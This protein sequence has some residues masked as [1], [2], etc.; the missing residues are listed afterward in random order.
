MY[1]KTLELFIF[2]LL[3]SGDTAN[4]IFI[5]NG[6]LLVIQNRYGERFRMV[7]YHSLDNK[8]FH[9]ILS[10][11]VLLQFEQC[12]HRQRVD[13]GSIFLLSFYLF[14]NHSDHMISS[15]C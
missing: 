14:T 8:R 9:N 5:S 1:I 3:C 13:G 7:T 6:P 2:C 10:V 11:T 12:P 15:K 4:F